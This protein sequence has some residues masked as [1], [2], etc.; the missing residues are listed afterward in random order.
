MVM[1]TNVTNTAGSKKQTNE[2]RLAGSNS[3]MLQGLH[4]NTSLGVTLKTVLIRDRV[5]MEGKSY[6]GVLRLDGQSDYLGYEDPHFTFF[7]SM[8]TTCTKRNPHVFEGRYINVSR[9]DDGSLCPH[10]KALPRSEDFNL[11]TYADGVASELRQA[12]KCLGEEG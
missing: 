3:D 12:L 2:P 5:P 1:K 7:E 8:Q 10:F 4:P 9:R 11:D 6:K